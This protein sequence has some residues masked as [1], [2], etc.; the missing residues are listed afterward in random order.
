[1]SLSGAALI[2]LTA[3]FRALFR[4]RA[5]KRV[6]PVLWGIA[7]ARLLLP[8][9]LAM[10]GAASLPGRGG[11]AL[12]AVGGGISELLAT[13]VPSGAPGV[14]GGAAPAPAVGGVTWGTVLT[15]L[16]LLGAALCAGWFAAAALWGRRERRNALPLED[17]DA[18]AWL[19]SHKLIRRVELRTLPGLTTPLT[20]GVLRP[21]I[22][23][24]GGM[25]WSAE[26][27]KYTL[28]HE[29]IHI[30]RFDTLTK[31]LA[32]AA[33]CVHW[34]NP[35]VWLLWALLNRDIELACDEAV[36]RRFGR[37]RRGEY[38]RMLIDMEERRMDLSPLGSH[39]ARSAIEE[40]ILS[41]MKIKK[42]TAI[43]IILAVA[44]VAVCVG[45]FTASALAPEKAEEPQGFSSFGAYRV[46]G[47]VAGEDIGSWQHKTIFIYEPDCAVWLYQNDPNDPSWQISSLT[48]DPERLR[49]IYTNHPEELTPTLFQ[50]LGF[51]EDEIHTDVDPSTDNVKIYL[52]DE[53][54]SDEPIYF[55]M[56]EAEGK[57]W[58]F[59]RVGLS[60]PTPVIWE[61]TKLTDDEFEQLIGKNYDE[62][63]ES[64]IKEAQGT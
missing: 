14:P 58:R 25:D 27:A 54:T 3:A 11:E 15:A 8:V 49:E 53:K 35:A 6:F 20:Y 62:T 41:I 32:A 1:M 55:A 36:V 42:N 9:S 21:V 22:L 39:F 19:A 59:E 12:D 4:D 43:S 26:T 16:W 37:E 48:I 5:P 61:L 13:A 63:V 47:V 34:F 50:D 7:L 44:L 40:R 30:R 57:L 10:P 52:Y 31:L 45:V 28:C 51:S 23:V 2:L 33:L 24:P 46:T 17:G 18:R 38:A 56:I 64:L 60:G 29:Y